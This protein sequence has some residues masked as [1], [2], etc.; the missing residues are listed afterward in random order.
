MNYN[1]TNPQK[2][3]LYTEQY[4]K[5]TVV[6]NICGTVL[7]HQKI[8][9]PKLIQAID[10]FLKDND[11]L[12]L[13]LTLDKNQEFTQYVSE[14]YNLGTNIISVKNDQE[15][16][17]LENKMVGIPFTLLDSQLSYIQLFS[18][19]DGTGGFIVNAH[20]LVV[21]ACSA[22]LIASK[23]TT[24]Y[25]AL[26]KGEEPNLAP[27]SYLNYVQ[28]EKEYLESPKFEKDKQYW[29]GVFEKAYDIGSIPSTR[30]TV[31]CRAVRKSFLF[32][33]EKVKQISEF[34]SQNRISIFNFFMALYA[35]YIEKLTSLKE[36]VIGTP[37]LNRTT[38]VEK[39]TPGMFI[40][41]MPFKFCINP[42]ISF[43]EFAKGI[44]L[45]ALGMFRHQKYPYPHILEYIRSKNPS[46]PNL[47]DI[48]ISYQN[49]KTNRNDSDI[50]Y[51]VRWTFNHNVA[52]SM[53]IH[54]F[55][56]NDEGIL[57]IAYDYRVDK[58]TEEDIQ[59][60]HTR[61]CYMV[62]QLL[63]N[64]QLLIENMSVV[65]EDEKD[66]LLNKFNHTDLPYDENKTLI[67][68]FEEQVEKTPNRIAIMFQNKSLTYLEL[69]KK[70]NSLARFL[71][72]KNIKNN[73]IVGVMLNR[74][75]EM[76][77]SILAVLKAGRSLYSN[78]P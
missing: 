56:M 70:A 69:N 66:K 21:D 55:D 47:Y 73:C 65:T 53:Q 60:L 76:M 7:I 29:E 35:I 63:E 51:E 22:S 38:F 37:I 12:R 23:I 4:F 48:L 61:I 18:F 1:L 75:L 78:R 28:S 45:D 11:G 67:D 71:R 33:E 42:N 19:P 8:D 3:I 6:N 14:D 20:H 39:N 5:G 9:F 16:V 59:A 32:P 46:Q 77:V 34:C 40:S 30:E 36:F 2:S 25:S 50:A 13:R 72:S 57:N 64:E 15:L 10:I 31:S 24:I 74:S 54:L 62:D 27:T 58:Y 44:A 43:V 17:A 49:T 26:L 68:Y 41:T 52:D